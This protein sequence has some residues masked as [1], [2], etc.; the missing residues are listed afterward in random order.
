MKKGKKMRIGLLGATG[1]VGQQYV[2]LLEGHPLFEIVHL[3]AGPNSAGKKYSETVAGR[4]KLSENLPE[5]ISNLTVASID[6]VEAAAKNCDLIFSALDSATA[7]SWE[8]NYASAGLPLVSNASAH[9]KTV[10]IPMI[11][12]EI[13]SSHLELIHEQQ[14]KR[15]WSKGFI[16]VKPNCSI[17]SYMTP[18]SVI[19]EKFKLEKILV[20]TMQAISGA[21]YPGVPSYD[22][23]DNIIPFINGEE[24][25]TENEPLKIFGKIE[26]GSLIPDN[27]ITIS[28]HCNRVPV[29]DGHMACVS[30]SCRQKPSYEEIIDHWIH[31]KAEPQRL[32]LHT[33]PSQPIIYRN[34]IDRP[35]PRLD[36]DADKGMAVTV[37]R[38]RTDPLLQWKFTGLSHN[39]IRGAAGGGILIGELLYAKGYISHE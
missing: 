30:F 14:R 15:G 6:D 31:F 11:I 33:S 3:A 27:S 29:I 16:V 39:T 2:A 34:E 21:G 23:L 12:P 37:G 19:H 28:A 32:N 24:E 9:R 36:K 20:T 26:H 22:I 18:L 38:L 25:K 1:V 10:D 35:Q 4:W 5:A 8:E 7:L 13:N 17:Q